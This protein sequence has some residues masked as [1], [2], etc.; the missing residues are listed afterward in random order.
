MNTQ[1]LV[2]KF[3]WCFFF[4]CGS[5]R[6]EETHQ[7]EHHTLVVFTEGK[8]YGRAGGKSFEAGAGD[9]VLYRAGEKYRESNDPG[10]PPA[11]YV[12]QFH[13]DEDFSFVRRPMRDRE[14]RVRTLCQWLNEQWWWATEADD[15]YKHGIL[16]AIIAE[17]LHIKWA[18]V[19]PFVDA[20]QRYLVAHMAEPVTTASLARHFRM[21][22]SYFC[23]RFRT[24]AHIAPMAELQKLRLFQARSFLQT[25]DM[26]VKQIARKVGF[27]DTAA[28]THL[29]RRVMNTTPTGIRKGAGRSREENIRLREHG[30]IEG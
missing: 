21:S 7:H 23:R 26:P 29:F 22:R 18:S 19:D 16:G 8:Y 27:S 14:G 28:L 10:D 4:R 1:A 24:E 2:R 30:Q 6:V 25:T 3:Y 15:A 20:V 13:S 11:F 12:I 9:I 17:L 5:E